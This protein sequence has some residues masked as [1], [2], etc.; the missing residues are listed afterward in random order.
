MFPVNHSPS[1]SGSR[2]PSPGSKAGSTDLSPLNSASRA[3]RWLAPSPRTR[4][5]G[6]I[7][8]R[9]MIFAAR[10]LP[11][12]GRDSRTA[13]TRILPITSSVSPCLR[14][15]LTVAPLLLSR[16]RSSARALRAAAAFSSAAARCSGVRSGRGMVDPIVSFP[17]PWFGPRRSRTRRG[18]LALSRDE[19]SSR[20]IR[21]SR[22]TPRGERRKSGGPVT[23][24]DLTGDDLSSTQVRGR[25][26]VSE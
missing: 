25:S 12:P 26:T 10:A 21:W 1:S 3:L 15:S 17:G 22:G 6:E 23:T 4:R 19:P 14:T 18:G 9:S 2:S 5:V 16:S 24:V 8:R 20:Q 7:S 11:T 13:E